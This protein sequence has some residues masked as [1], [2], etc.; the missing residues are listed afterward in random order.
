MNDETNIPQRFK[1][2]PQTDAATHSFAVGQSVRLNGGFLRSGTIYQITAR[3]PPV[4]DSPQ[5]RIRN[6]EE[7][8]ERVARQSE[9][10]PSSAATEGAT[11]SLVEKSFGLG[12][13]S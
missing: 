1:R 7:K 4:G 2:A 12:P 5:Y 6:D 11:T 13:R 9:L 10:E 8:F 3:L